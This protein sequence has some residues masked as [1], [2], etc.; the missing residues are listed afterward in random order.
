M[1]WQRL[2]NAALRPITMTHTQYLVL[3]SLEQAGGEHREDVSQ[4]EIARQ[5]G[6]DEATTSN[7]IQAL[8]KRGLVSREPPV[9]DYR[10]WGVTLTA[11]GVR[12]LRRAGPL[13]EGAGAEFRSGTGAITMT[14]KAPS[15]R[16]ARAR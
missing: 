5:A 3:S 12:S 15:K 2:V 11:S 6:L 13:V 7:V 8:E 9:E 16:A 1:R 4:R 10:S 14:G